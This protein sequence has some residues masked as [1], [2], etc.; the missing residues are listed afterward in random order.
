MTW[1][2]YLRRT[3]LERL[4]LRW[5]PAVTYHSFRVRGLLDPELE[6]LCKQLGPGFCA[7]DVGAND[8]VYTHA[9]A[10]TG[11][12]VEAFE[13]QPA[14]L[15]ILESY[16][17]SRANVR[18]HPEALGASEHAAAL[19][20]PIRD[21]KPVSGHASLR[22]MEGPA[23]AHDV[24]V[25][26]LD[27]FALRDVRVIKIDVEGGEADVLSGAQETID[28]WRPTLLVEIE[29]R[30][31][32]RPMEEVFAIALGFGYVG[33]F[34]HPQHGMLPLDAFDEKK[35]QNPSNAD[36]PHALYLN[37]FI[38]SPSK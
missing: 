37:N 16:G 22:R 9:F 31:L 12:R 36:R 5:R 13:P 35:H 29:Q 2:S 25:R 3:V 30:H 10:R 17:R 28:Q 26:T 21:G 24:Y 8:G 6:L 15:E 4:P 11:A 7:I 18:V 20:I 23:S 27:S 14:C 33:R 38:F 19:I 32:R 1:A 34:F